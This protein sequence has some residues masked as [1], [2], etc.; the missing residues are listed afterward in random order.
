MNKIEIGKT[1]RTRRENL[2]LKQE[3]LAEMSGLTLKTIHLAESG[4]GN[5]SL[6]TLEKIATILGMELVLQIKLNK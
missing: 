6:K 2:G 3:D 5:P 4:K 1:A